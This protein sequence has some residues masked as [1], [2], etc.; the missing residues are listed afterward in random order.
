MDNYKKINLEFLQ[1]FTQNDNA[2]MAKYIN[3]F[4]TLAPVSINTMKT[5]H[6]CGDWNNLRTTAIGVYGHR[7]PERNHSAHRRIRRRSQKP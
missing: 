7:K 3:M 6:E 5:Q 4:L 2:Q 1:S